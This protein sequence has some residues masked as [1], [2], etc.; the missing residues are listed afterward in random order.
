[1]LRS[2]VV[3]SGFLPD[4]VENEYN[5][6][7]MDRLNV[8]IAHGEYDYVY[9]I[10]WGQASADYFE[11]MQANVTYF[12]FEDGH[13]VTPAVLEALTAFLKSTMPDVLE[14]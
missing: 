6:A 14:N 11:R 7:P 5:K 9:P 3:L 8:F 4:F 13:G 2:V 10:S 12:T 1:M